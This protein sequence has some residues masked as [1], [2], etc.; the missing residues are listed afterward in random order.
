MILLK[1]T[2]K[3]REENLSLKKKEKKMIYFKIMNVRLPCKLPDNLRPIVAAP[4]A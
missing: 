1:E 3:S 2:W 4:L